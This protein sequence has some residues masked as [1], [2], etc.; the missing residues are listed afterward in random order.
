LSRVSKKWKGEVDKHSAL[1]KL[2]RRVTVPDGRGGGT[3][4]WSEERSPKTTG[5]QRQYFQ[6]MNAAG[7]RQPFP[8][9]SEVNP[10]SKEPSHLT[11]VASREWKGEELGNAAR[12]G[13][14][15][16]KTYFSGSKPKGSN[17]LKLSTG[18]QATLQSKHAKYGNR[19]DAAN[20]RTNKVFV[21]DPAGSYVDHAD[22]SKRYELTPEQEKQTLQDVNARWTGK[23]IIT[24]RRP[25]S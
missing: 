3:D 4:L 18:E 23:P 9:Y 24:R 25:T 5:K 7:D 17:M 22:R 8:H 13:R 21:P 6:P 15:P 10:R 19:R 11:D 20:S 1:P 14:Y 12:D 16:T 2:T